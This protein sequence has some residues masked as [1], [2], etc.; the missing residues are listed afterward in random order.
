MK[1]R[2]TK[3]FSIFLSIIIIVVFASEAYFVVTNSNR[4]EFYAEGE[5]QNMSSGLYSGYIHSENSDYTKIKA[6][7][8]VLID[9]DLDGDLDLTYGYSDS[10]YFKNNEGVFEDITE[11]YSCLLY[12]S[13]SPRDLS[14]SRMPSSA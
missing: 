2:Y 1:N 3:I 13:P 6:K 8:G 12:T 14:T 10:Y 5:P 9:F 7:G 4:G 11:E